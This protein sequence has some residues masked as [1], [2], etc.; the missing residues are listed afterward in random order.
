MTRKKKTPVKLFNNFPSEIYLT[1]EGGNGEESYFLQWENKKDAAENAQE[2][3][4]EIA[5]YSL[6]DQG[7]AS[8]GYVITIESSL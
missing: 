2:N 1:R 4:S 3:D 6:R 8:V 7:K 5:I